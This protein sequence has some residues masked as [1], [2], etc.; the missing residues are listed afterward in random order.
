MCPHCKHPFCDDCAHHANSTA[1]N[2]R[3][4]ECRRWSRAYDWAEQLM[5]LRHEGLATFFG[6]KIAG[7]A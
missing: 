6:K 3:C 4:C 2:L 1:L 7:H 5:L